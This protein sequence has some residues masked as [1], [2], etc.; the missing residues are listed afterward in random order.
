M[1]DPRTLEKVLSAA[2]AAVTAIDGGKAS[3]DDVLDRSAPEYRRTLEH[4]LLN[5]FRFRKSIRKLWMSFCQRPPAP[6]IAVLLD[7]ALCQSLRQSAVAPQ[8]VVNVA[9]SLAKRRRADKFVNAIMR[10][11]LAANWSVPEKPDDILPNAVLQWWRQSFSPP[12]IE[13]FAQ[14]F[15]SEVPFSFRLCRDSE[16]PENC[17]EIPVD[18]KFRFATGNGREII[19]S[20]PF[21]QGRYYVQDPAAAMAVSLAADKIATAGTVLDLCAAPGGK[22]LLMAELLAP[23]AR[24]TAADRSA[25]RQQLTAEN[26]R[27]FNVNGTIIT[28]TPEK[29]RGKF[30]LVFADVPCSNTGV[31]R[32]RPDALWRFSPRALNEVIQ[33]QR[34]IITAAALL[35]APDGTLV[36]S[37]CSIDPTENNAM[38]QT[39]RELGFTLEISRT[40]LPDAACDGAFGAVLSR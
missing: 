38:I 6:E 19:A 24:L 27:K 5:L 34:Q 36:C 4:L 29:I 11:S 2:I 12:E 10:K 9:V 13:K 39:A 20:E 33:L 22:S 18:G 23:N 17:T 30:D 14:L 16:L 37:S 3:L 28:A 15:I 35:V 31:F 25:R 8:S 1:S 7:T 40:L 32:R 26:F 21:R